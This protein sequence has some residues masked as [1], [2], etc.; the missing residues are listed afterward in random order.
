MN[1]RSAAK[2]SIPC[3]SL[4]PRRSFGSLRGVHGGV[5]GEERVRSFW[6]WRV[7]WRGGDL[8][9]H[10]DM[11]YRMVDRNLNS[12]EIAIIYLW[13]RRRKTVLSTFPSTIGLPE[14]TGVIKQGTKQDRAR[15]SP[16]EPDHYP[17]QPQRKGTVGGWHTSGERGWLDCQKHKRRIVRGKGRKIVV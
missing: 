2:L 6:Q 14:D 5:V 10:Q 16:Q 11:M 7:A 12:T 17:L 13:E 15:N 4:A 3:S 8:Y 9:S 1:V